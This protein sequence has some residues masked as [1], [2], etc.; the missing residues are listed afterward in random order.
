MKIA[1]YLGS[2]HAQPF[3]ENQISSLIDDN[4]KVLIFGS[5][6]HKKFF[7]NYNCVKLYLTPRN[8]IKRIFYSI[9]SFLKLLIFYPKRFIKTIFYIKNLSNL[10]IKEKLNRLNTIIPLI[11]N[12]PDIM[13]IQWAKSIDLWFFLKTDFNVKIVLSLR[14]THINCSPLNDKVLTKLYKTTFPEIDRFHAVS[15]SLEH[16]ALKYGAKKNKI[17]VIYS[18][19]NFKK[20]YKKKDNWD[21]QNTIKVL[22]VGR[23]N[24][25]KG[26]HIALS[27]IKILHDQG[28]DINYTIIIPDKPSEEV[29]YQ[30]EN[31][32][33]SNLVYFK[34]YAEQHKIYTLMT[35]SDCLLLPS[36]SE[37]IANVV[38]EAMSVNLPV[39]S[40]DCGGMKEIIKDGYNGYL[41][42]NRDFLSLVNSFNIFLNTSSNEKETLVRNAK[43]YILKNNNI[44]Y[45]GEKMKSLYRKSLI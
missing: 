23:S 27:A 39:I 13:H 9:Y 17:D 3:I 44:I 5:S 16:E 20:I 28:H 21:L 22:S 7:N 30:I 26:Y 32:R 24:W 29:L 31:L 11:I 25:V 37:G 15:K 6:I 8:I 42:K 34:S 2:T 38:Y 18:P 40:S 36:I 43:D 19:I 4:I 12:L 10:S 35:E 45:V 1:F 14:G 33:I 41:F